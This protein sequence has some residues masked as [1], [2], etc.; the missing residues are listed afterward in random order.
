MEEIHGSEAPPIFGARELWWP[1]VSEFEKGAAR[2]PRA[3]HEL[4]G[5]PGK[6]FVMLARAEPAK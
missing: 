4:V 3:F 2:N 5:R 6:G 1:S